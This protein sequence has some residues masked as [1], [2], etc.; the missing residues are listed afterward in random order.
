MGVLVSIESVAGELS[1]YGRG[2]GN[3]TAGDDFLANLALI[4]GVREM[5][6]EKR[7][8]RE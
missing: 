5:Q 4:Q 2:G 1:L 8:S 7:E 6:R 3:L